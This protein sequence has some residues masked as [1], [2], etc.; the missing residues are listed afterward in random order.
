M[1]SH[2]Y[3]SSS[4]YF[5]RLAMNVFSFFL[6]VWRL[7][8]SKRPFRNWLSGVQLT[9]QSLG[10]FTQPGSIATGSSEEQVP[11]CP[12]CRDSDHVPQRS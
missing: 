7:Q 2:F 1:T 5:R 9:E 6:R 10:V 4:K 11:P 8:F 12:L 3:Y